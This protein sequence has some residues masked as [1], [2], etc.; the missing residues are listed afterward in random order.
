VFTD[1][2]NPG[3]LLH[4]KLLLSCFSIDKNTDELVTRWVESGSVKQGNK[5]SVKYLYVWPYTQKEKDRFLNNCDLN[6][7]G[8]PSFIYDRNDSLF[9]LRT[10]LL[11]S[12]LIFIEIFFYLYPIALGKDIHFEG[13]NWSDMELLTH[14]T[15]FSADVLIN[16][17]SSPRDVLM[18]GWLRLFPYS[19][20]QNLENILHKDVFKWSTLHSLI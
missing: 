5:W 6:W 12:R 17:N 1:S 13:L 14:L 4:G 8:E 20:K 16:C 15:S 11:T 18:L 9:D 7:W 10:G 2:Y 3:V 19:E